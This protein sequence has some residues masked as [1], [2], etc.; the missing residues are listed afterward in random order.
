MRCLW[1]MVLIVALTSCKGGGAAGEAPGVAA[2]AYC[3][4]YGIFGVQVAPLTY[5][6]TDPSK[7]L[8]SAEGAGPRTLNLTVSSGVEPEISV[9]G[10]YSPTKFRVLRG[11]R[12]RRDPEHHALRGLQ[13]PHS[14]LR[15]RARRRVSVLPEGRRH[16]RRRLRGADRRRQR[17]GAQAGR[18]LLR[19]VRLH[20]PRPLRREL[21][22]RLPVRRSRLAC[23]PDGRRRRWQRGGRRGRRHGRLGRGS[24]RRRVMRRRG[25]AVYCRA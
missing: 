13:R 5:H 20:Q 21:L 8:E 25:K 1:R 4:S 15:V 23:Q 12:L 19:H 16:H 10:T 24:G 17:P 18:R 11:A 6:W 14:H 22:R 3:R 2:E 7:L 9:T